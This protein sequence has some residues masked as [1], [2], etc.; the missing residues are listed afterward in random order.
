MQTNQQF[1]VSVHVLTVLAAYPDKPV[2]SETIAESVDTNPVVI[3]R[4]MGH[5]RKHG[6]VDSRPGTSGGW[7]LRRQAAEISLSEVYRI[8][9]HEDVLGMH[10]HPNPDCPI[11]SQIQGALGPIFGA[12]QTAMETALEQYTVADVLEE[13]RNEKVTNKEVLQ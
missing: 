8:V 13:V 7:R 11:G 9:S 6:L 5:L 4:V 10:S 1:A 12:A 3:R 2:T